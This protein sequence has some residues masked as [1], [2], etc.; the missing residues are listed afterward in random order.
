MLFGIAGCNTEDGALFK[1]FKLLFTVVE[2]LPLVA[3]VKPDPLPGPVAVINE[4]IDD[5]LCSWLEDKFGK[6]LEDFDVKVCPCAVNRFEAGGFGCM[7]LDEDVGVVA[8]AVTVATPAAATAAAC[9]TAAEAVEDR[10]GTFA[11]VGA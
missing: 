7:V 5:A 3:G 6:A 9:A 1:E 8:E 11:A 4:E 2:L 10:G